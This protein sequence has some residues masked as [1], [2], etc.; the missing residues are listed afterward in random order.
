MAYGSPERIEDVPA[1]Y[2]DIRGGRPIRPELL[3]ELTQ[4]YRR[5]RVEGGEP[6][7]REH[8][9]EAGCAPAAARAAR[10]HRNEAL[11]AADR[12]CGRDCARGW[13][14]DDRRARARA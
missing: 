6:P 2:S 14:R 7:Q 12:G 4:R 3:E 9:A 1:Y 11:D 8:R 5:A 10:A 13:G